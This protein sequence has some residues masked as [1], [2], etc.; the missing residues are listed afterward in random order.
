VAP[1]RSPVRI[2]CI[3]SSIVPFMSKTIVA[4]PVL[5]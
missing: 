1:V 5:Q 3:A 2:S 4:V